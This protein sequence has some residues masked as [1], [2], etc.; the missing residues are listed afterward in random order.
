M[1]GRAEVEDV[2][3]AGGGQPASSNRALLGVFVALACALSVFRFLDADELEHL[4]ATWLVLNGQVPFRDFFEHHHPLAWFTLAPVLAL[5]G[6]SAAAVIAFRLVF[7]GLTLAIVR[8]TYQ[9]ALEC[10]PSRDVAR[11]AALLLVSMTTFVYVAIEIRPDVPQMFFTVVSALYLVRLFRTQT[12]RDALLSGATAAIAFLFLQK[13]V[14]V[15]AAYPALFLFHILRRRLPWSAALWFA[16][17]FLLACVPFLAYLVATGSL[18]DYVTTNW[19]INIRVGATGH[20]VSVLSPEVLRDVVRNPV[21]WSLAVAAAVAALR[22]RLDAAYVVPACLGF[23]SLCLI[24]ALNRVV[25]RYVAATIPFL[26]IAAAAWLREGL[27]RFAIGGWRAAALLVLTCLVPGVAMVRAVGLSNR[28][29]LEQIQYVLDHSRREDRVYDY[30]RNINIFRPDTHYFWFHVGRAA[31]I[32][33]TESGGRFS[34]AD[35]CRAIIAARPLFVYQR[36]MELERCGV[37]RAYRPTP[38]NN[39]FVRVDQ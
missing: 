22:R 39:L 34:G 17:A 24:V 32:Y 11:L 31:A 21:F 26:A 19:L 23:V 6:E 18:H 7:F 8:A 4:H 35:S 15:L 3:P 33:N 12:A 9:L 2:A 37:A 14:L 25:D 30:E 10:R 36:R 27:A 29:Q 38:V 16:V 20:R 1:A 5:T 13:A 28:P